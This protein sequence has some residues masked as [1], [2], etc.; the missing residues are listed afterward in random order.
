MDWTVIWWILAA[1]IVVFSH[2]GNKADFLGGVTGKNAGQFGVMLFFIL[3]G[4]LMSYLYMNRSFT[5][6][7]VYNFAVARFARVVPLFVFVVLLSYAFRVNGLG[8]IYNIPSVEILISHLTLLYG[9]AVLWTIG[10]EIQFY[11][12]FVGLW[13]L[14]RVRPG[15]VYL[16]MTLVFFYL[17]MIDFPR[18]QGSSA[19]GIRYDFSIVPSLQYFFVGVAFGQLYR[20]WQAPAYWRRHIF[21]LSFGLVILLYPEIFK[22]LFGR[23]HRVWR[24]VGV[25]MMLSSV[26]FCLVF[27]VP[28]KSPVLA[29]R[30]GD[31]LGKVSFSLYLWHL[32]ILMYFRNWFSADPEIRL[33]VYL[34]MI[35][36]ASWLSY[37]IIEAPSRKWIRKAAS[38]RPGS[39]SA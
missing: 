17:V 33:P 37:L 30:V 18:V 9:H 25:L 10:P 34:A 22:E 36:F 27:L 19:E 29:N 21:L 39:S 6:Q 2:Y 13:A 7:E 20:H 3:S 12:L 32:P 11:V 4:F 5:R 14:F 35:L 23:Q 31:F 8:L 15:Y 28:D 26:F 38:W 16:L 1:L 24:D